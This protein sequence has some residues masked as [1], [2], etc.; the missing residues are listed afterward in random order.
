MLRTPKRKKNPQEKQED[1]RKLTSHTKR[2]GKLAHGKKRE[3]AKQA[4]YTNKT[5]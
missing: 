3:E 5:T 2:D 4:S 1:K